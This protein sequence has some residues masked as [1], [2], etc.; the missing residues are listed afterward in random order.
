M[1]RISFK[2]LFSVFVLTCF[3]FA[4]RAVAGPSFKANPS[5]KAYVGET[6]SLDLRSLLSGEGSGVLTW[7]G[8]ADQPKWMNIDSRISLATGQPAL[9]DVGTD[10]FQLTVT[11]NTGAHDMAVV[12]VVVTVRPEWKISTGDTLDLG[13]VNEGQPLN[14]SL[15]NLVTIPAGTQI[16]FTATNL[17]GW[18]HLNPDGALSGTPQRADVGSD[19]GIQFIATTAAGEAST[20]S[21][22]VQVQKVIHPPKWIKPQLSAFQAKADQPFQQDIST[23]VM[24]SE[25]AQL[26]FDLPPNS[27]APTWLNITSAGLL[28]GEPGD[29]DVGTKVFSARLTGTINGTTYQ[30]TTLVSVSVTG[31][32]HPPKWKANPL[33]LPPANSGSPY[34]QI[35]LDSVE[36]PDGGPLTFSLATQPGDWV[37]L[38]PKTAEFKGTPPAT[39]SGVLTWVA[40]VTNQ[41]G[42]TDQ[43]TIQLNVIRPP[44]PPRWNA[45]PVAL[46]V[47]A[48]EEKYFSLDLTTLVKNPDN[49]SLQFVKV[50]GPDKNDWAEVTPNGILQGIPTRANLPMSA[51][52]V[53]VTS[54]SGNDDTTINIP[55]LKVNHPPEWALSP[56]KLSANQGQLLDE[57]LTQ[58]ASSPDGD[59]LTFSIL[60]VVGPAWP[61]VSADGKHFGGTPA[62]DETQPSQVTVQAADNFGGQTSVTILISVNHVDHPPYWIKNPTTLPDAAVGTAY[63]QSLVTYAKDPDVGDILHFQKISGPTWL[64]VDDSGSVR[65]TPPAS[66]VGLNNFSIEVRDS[67]DMA[68]TASVNINVAAGLIVPKWLQNPVPLSNATPSVAYLFDLSKYANDAN[69]DTLQFTKISGPTWMIVSQDGTISGT[70]GTNDVGAFTATFQASNGMATAQATANGLVVGSSKAPQW[71]TIPLNF[72]SPTVGT[73]FK[74][75]LSQYVINLASAQLVY[76]KVQGPGWFNVSTAGLV[77]GT[78]QASDAGSFTATVSVSDG[79]NNVTNNII[80]TVVGGSLPPI[81]KTIALTFTEGGSY[82]INLNSSQYV[83]P[84]GAT[85]LTFQIAG[86]PASGWLTVSSTGDLKANPKPGDRGNYAMTLTVSNGTQVATGPITALVNPGDNPP[87]WLQDNFQFTATVNQSFNQSL[88]NQAKDIVG[89]PVTFSKASGP[90]WLT[91]SSAGVL[92]GTPTTAEA[93][94]FVVN[95]TNEDGSSPANVTVTVAGNG[96][97]LAWTTPS[98]PLGT[99]IAVGSAFTF[100][101]TKFVK[102]GVKTP[103]FSLVS[104]PSWMQVGSNGQITGSPHASDASAFVTTFSA[105]DGQTTVT[106]GGFGTVFGPNSNVPVVLAINLTVPAGGQSVFHLSDPQYITNP[107]GG[108]LTFTLT[109]PTASYFSLAA[110]GDVSVQPAAGDVGSHQIQFTVAN[111]AGST[112]GQFTITVIQQLIPATWSQTSITMTAK[113]N[114]PFTGSLTSYAT[115]P[116]GETLVFAK[117]VGPAWLTVAPSGALSGTPTAS[118][119]TTFILTVSAQGTTS[120]DVASLT[121]TFTSTAV[122]QTIA[123]DSCPNG[124]QTSLLWVLDHTSY[125]EQLVNDVRTSIGEFYNGLETAEVTSENAVGLTNGILMGNPALFQGQDG[126]TNTSAFLARAGFVSQS[127]NYPLWSLTQFFSTTAATR[128]PQGFE[129]A[130]TP[131]EVVFVTAARDEYAYS[132]PGYMTYFNQ[133]A[134]AASVPM[135]VDTITRQCP[136]LGYTPGTA[137]QLAAESTYQNL[138]TATGGSYIN[139]CEGKIPD[140]L[141]QFATFVSARAC[142][143]SHKVVTLSAAPTGAISVTLG[144]TVLTGNTG[145]ATDQWKYNSTTN[146]VSILWHNI[147]LNSITGKESLTIKTG[148]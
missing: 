9:T 100:D 25:N 37:I 51:Y 72:G 126:S 122:G 76:S 2:S 116:P 81:I 111:S 104:G 44:E 28:F 60:N 138:V 41:A 94:T 91:V 118:T 108:S 101:L 11:D 34:D 19:T 26:A 62:V 36:N 29:K 125:S 106:T 133:T 140:D 56:I 21:A 103:T 68:A 79:T 88:A 55:I 145:A 14:V 38:D 17:P 3:T 105:T 120:V 30:D 32:A 18:L 117:K 54:A 66:A 57:D 137:L 98:I 123:L 113:L 144:T 42:L 77:S 92:S 146:Q 114:Q 59:T 33:N 61:T 22:K 5:L 73:S 46:G 65:G 80:G 47:S 70:P 69:N 64:I 67:S 87:L 83:D 53:R 12:S 135:R 82:D 131:V 109:S 10:S 8:D 110:N 1:F 78:P 6:L 147:N 129:I 124:A 139:D 16:A 141:T 48:E 35:L 49:I 31:T 112:N 7:A 43:T 99:N 127:D 75:D 71:S 39:V 85:N 97:A 136:Y 148:N 130:E 23:Q 102:G 24:N 90:S 20:V 4:A 52:Q 143:V 121:F 13:V 107:A 132:T 84:Q 96:N 58:W 134:Q 142:A 40:K 128:L 27:G 50:V 74:F 95:A 63:V 115:P 15:Q 89:R 93:D 86:A 119:D 45:H